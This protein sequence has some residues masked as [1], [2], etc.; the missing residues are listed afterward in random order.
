MFALLPQSYPQDFVDFFTRNYFRFLDIFHK[1]LDNFEIKLFYNMFNNLN[2]DLKFYLNW[3]IFE[4]F[5]GLLSKQ[6][7]TIKFL[8]F[9]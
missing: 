6:L 4:I 5:L 1:W 8:K 9:F 2:P 7:V 3:S